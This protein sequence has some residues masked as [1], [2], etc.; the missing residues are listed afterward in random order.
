M[1]KKIKAPNREG[2]K[3]SNQFQYLDIPKDQDSCFYNLK[4]VEFK[5]IDEADKYVAEFEVLDTDTKQHIGSKVSHMM[6]PFQ[7][8]AETYFWKDIFALHITLKGKAITQKRLDALLEDHEAALK[9]LSSGKR[10]GCVCRCSIKRYTRDGKDKTMRTW[11]P[12]TE[13]A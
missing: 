9:V 5:Y 11:E 7:K 3:P 4:L 13:D 8:F 1:P 2:I 12:A 10:N 6:D